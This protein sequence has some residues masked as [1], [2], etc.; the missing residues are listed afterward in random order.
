MS[1]VMV[2]AGDMDCCKELAYQ[3]SGRIDDAVNYRASRWQRTGLLLAGVPAA[4]SRAAELPRRF[5]RS[6][7]ASWAPIVAG[8]FIDALEGQLAARDDVEARRA[9]YSLW[10]AGIVTRGF[11][12]KYLKHRKAPGTR[13]SMRAD[14]QIAVRRLGDA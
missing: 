6:S 14:W 11:L 12:D 5:V 9:L 3:E 13:P 2:E 7:G 10:L 1:P 4:P 8:A